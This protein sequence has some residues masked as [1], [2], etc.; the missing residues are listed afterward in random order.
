[1]AC[2]YVAYFTIEFRK[3]LQFFKIAYLTWKFKEGAN[4]FHD[5]FSVPTIK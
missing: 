1:M 3:F 2:V 4:D 5:S